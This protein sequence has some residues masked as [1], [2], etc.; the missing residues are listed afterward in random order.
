VAFL[1]DC[2]VELGASLSS[3]PVVD[4]SRLRR[5]T[6]TTGNHAP[7]ESRGTP[8]CRY[9][10]FKG[11]FT[12]TNDHAAVPWR[13]CARMLR[14]DIEA[15]SRLPCRSEAARRAP[16]PGIWPRA[17]LSCRCPQWVESRNLRKRANDW[18]HAGAKVYSNTAY[19]SALKAIRNEDLQ[20]LGWSA[21]LHSQHHSYH[22]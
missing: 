7:C 20:S 2:S 10:A 15:L 22:S 13:T 9:I 6:Q 14:R 12:R 8:R 17:E 11:A 19:I 1:L 16:W 5:L 18:P 3:Y 4:R 21:C